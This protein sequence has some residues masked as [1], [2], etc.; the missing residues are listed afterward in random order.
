MNNYAQD[1]KNPVVPT[2]T[3]MK[4]R[5]QARKDYY[6]SKIQCLMN[7]NL[8]PRLILLACWDAPVARED[9]LSKRGQKRF[10]KKCLKFYRARL[11]EVEKKHKKFF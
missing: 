6:E 10:I 8:P 1:I 5:Y 11:K 2:D 4:I 9:L 3:N 7:M